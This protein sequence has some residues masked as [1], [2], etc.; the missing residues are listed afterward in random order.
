MDN[1][2]VNHLEVRLVF[3]LF[4]VQ[5]QFVCIVVAGVHFERDG[6]AFDAITQMQS[7]KNQV[8]LGWQSF[9]RVEPRLA[10]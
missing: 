8:K 6:F 2:G 1:G 10:R 7:L 9:F 4:R 3:A 5:M